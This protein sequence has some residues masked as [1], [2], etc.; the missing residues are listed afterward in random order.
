MPFYLMVDGDDTYPA[1]KAPELLCPL[2]EGS[3]DMVVG[4]RL[5]NGSYE[6]ENKR[7]FHGLGN[8]LVCALIKL[9][10]GF[11]YNDVMSGYRAFNRQFASLLPVL[12]DGFQIETEISIH[13]VDKQ[14]RIAQVPI[15]YRDRPEGSVSKLSTLNDG[16]K[17]LLTI[18]SLFKDYRPM[19]LFGLLS[20]FLLILGLCF[21]LPVVL[22]FSQTGLVP[23][24]P[25]AIVAAA[26][27]GASALSLVCGLILDTVVKEN[28]KT[29]SLQATGSFHA[30]GRLSR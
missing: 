28:R 5:S 29:Y 1:D 30:E 8:W 2:Y 22:E 23:R 14:W 6:S 16:V 7:A 24:L 12:S 27:V 4:D 17:V 3:A 10:Y 15:D 19:A 25:T 11:S 20:A 9:L 13:A 18:G 26:L 21:G